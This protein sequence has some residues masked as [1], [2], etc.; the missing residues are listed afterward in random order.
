MY[1]KTISFNQADP[2]GILFFAEAI[3]LSH[4]TFELFIMD[5]GILWEEWFDNKQWGVPIRHVEAEYFSPIFPGKQYDFDIKLKY[6]GQTSLECNCTISRENEI[7]SKIVTHHVFTSLSK[8]K[9]IKIPIE[10][11]KKLGL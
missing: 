6:K 4:Q 7:K 11:I 8:I 10:I 1:K 9:P 3:A 2:F 5:H